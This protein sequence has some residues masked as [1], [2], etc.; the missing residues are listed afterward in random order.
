MNIFNQASSGFI[1]DENN[2]VDVALMKSRKE[3]DQEHLKLNPAD[4]DY[5]KRLNALK[6]K[7]ANSRI[8]IQW[9][10]SGGFK[11]F[12]LRK[13]VVIGVIAVIV[14]LAE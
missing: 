10:A 12:I 2:P 4:P 11:G 13:V 8:K 7:E 14:F 5:K 9:D 1:H 3:Y 6:K